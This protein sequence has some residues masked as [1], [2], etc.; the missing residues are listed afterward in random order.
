MIWLLMSFSNLSPASYE[1]FVMNYQMN[2]LEK[3]LAELHGMLKTA[4]VSIKKPPSC[5]DGSEEEQKEEAL[6]TS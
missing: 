6:D 2:G 5:D 4:V 3:T 1:P